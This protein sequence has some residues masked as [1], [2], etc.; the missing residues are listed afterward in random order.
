MYMF[1][2]SMLVNVF[3]MCITLVLSLVLV[4]CFSL[5][6]DLVKMSVTRPFFFVS[7]FV[8]LSL[9]FLLILCSSL[10]VSQNL[11]PELPNALHLLV[12]VVLDIALELVEWFQQHS[13]L[14]AV[15]SAR[16]ISVPVTI[17]IILVIP[18]LEARIAPDIFLDRL[19]SRFGH[20]RSEHLVCSHTC[21]HVGC[22]KVFL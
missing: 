21:Q 17:A 19:D 6:A 3:K 1:S 15:L 18:P 8:S 14:C 7:L 5:V 22:P 11:L 13:H 16:R 10:I 9:S 2:L 4:L 20:V 12:H